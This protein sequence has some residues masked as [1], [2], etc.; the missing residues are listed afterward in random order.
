MPGL[1][2]YL[3]AHL[4]ALERIRD[5]APLLAV[6]LPL[7]T[8]SEAN[9]H[10]HWRQRAG[11][12]KAQRA[13]VGLVLAS[14]KASLRRWLA[15]RDLV[16]RLVRVAPR[17]LDSDNAAGS[18]KHVRDSVAEVLGVDDRSPRVVWVTDQRK[19]KTG[20]EIEVYA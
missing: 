1:T 10:A 13:A 7:V 9:A 2:P 14:S 20:V 4:A 12:A 3:A 16:V 15:G 17:L 8:V 19:G 5:Q 18:T 11:R 6:S